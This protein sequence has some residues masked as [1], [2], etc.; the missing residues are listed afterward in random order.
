MIITPISSK[1]Y[2]D[3]GNSFLNRFG[4]GRVNTQDLADQ[5]TD[6]A[7]DKA[8]DGVFHYIGV[9]ERAIRRDPLGQASSL[10]RQVFV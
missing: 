8:L 10:L 4:L 3:Q 7:V 6:H 9:E 5:V 1:P 2:V